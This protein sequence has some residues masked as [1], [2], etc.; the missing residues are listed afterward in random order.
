MLLALLLLAAG[1]G[2]R[3]PTP[4]DE[5][6]FALVAHQ[7]VASGNWL[8]PHRGSDWY[9]DKPPTF[10]A[11]QAASHALTGDWRVAFLLPSLLASLGTLWLVY[12][13]GRRLWN[14]RAGMW[15]ALA[16]LCT[17]QFVFQAKR[18][19]IDPTVTFF[20][21]AAN[22]GLL[23]HFLLGPDRRALWFGCFAAGLGVITKGVGVLAFLMLVP[24]LL[25][26]RYRW[27]GLSTA[28]ERIA[29]WLVAALA[30]LAAIAC[31][32]LPLAFY[33]HAHDSIAARDYVSDIFVNQTLHRYVHPWNSFQPPWFYLEVIFTSW[34][35]LS[36]ALPGLLPAWRQ[37]LREHDARFLLPL[38]WSVLVIVFFSLTR[39]K[40][41]VYIM[42]ALP[43]LA[44]CA[45]PFLR[46]ILQRRWAQWLAL[47]FVLA[48]AV[49]ALALGLLGMLHPTAW[50]R[51][52][53]EA[54]QLG[55]HASSLWIA[56]I[57][58]GI[59]MG[60]CI[61]ACR[62]RR[63]GMALLA[64]LA[65]LW[66]AWGLWVAPLL[67]R[68]SSQAPL[69]QRVEQT[70]GPDA[71]LALVAWKE[72]LPLAFQRKV[73]D[74]GFVTPWHEQ[75][76]AAIRWQQQSPAHRW[77]LVLSDVMAPCIDKAAT[78]DMGITSGRDWRLYRLDAVAPSCRG[79]VVPVGDVEDWG[80]ID[81]RR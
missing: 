12:D 26:R 68:A 16:L 20:V 49:P 36:L 31:W 80:G 38:A 23:R 9:S 61:A 5:P 3:T 18:G 44:L 59:W 2:M 70:I 79:G 14:H 8:I 64:G 17:V 37:R 4:S 78:L 35:P 75:L 63:A 66:L 74:F 69:V 71:E 30:F 62:L 46:D 81:K 29:T 22:A 21:T 51:H 50:T 7:M 54:R 10:M 11:M 42:P 15:A 53:V 58:I 1:I 48:L 47:A 72:E 39:A 57:V 34:L 60:L 33:L 6:R 32:L 55:D 52:F 19:Q 77:V 43:L 73:T 40:R 28:P 13:L 24:W 27:Q 67:A 56:C 45:G 41:D 25:A 65:G 76:A